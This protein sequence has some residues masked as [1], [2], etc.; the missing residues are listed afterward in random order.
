MSFDQLHRYLFNQA[1]VR[2]ELVR[3]ENS[4]Q[5]ILDSYAYPPVIQKLLGE[6]MAATSLLTAT[7]KFEGDIA[8]QLQSDG[9]VNYAVINGTHDQKLRGVARWD[10]SLSELPTDFSQLFQKGVLV[11]TITPTDG[12]RYQG[13][14]A[15]DKPTLAECIEGYFQ[16]SEQLATKVIL[17][18]QQTDTSAKAC[19]MFLQILPT[20]SQATITEDTGFDH[21]SKLTETIK[22]EELFTLPAEDILYRLYHQ[23]DVEVYAPADIIFK[24][25][26][27]RER[28]ANALAAV[29]K[30]ELLNIVATEGAI[31]MNCQYCHT[32]YRFDEIDVHAIHAGTFSMDTQSDQ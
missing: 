18:T 26:C 8:L 20:S 19:G 1:H 30:S 16:Q 29:E 7:L 11:I 12:E 24:C 27:S 25:S 17:R 14:V 5:S 32:E 23:E 10:E 15:L 4:Y 9:P 3:L 21:L 28:S 22:D 31:K 2:G 13:M 6:L